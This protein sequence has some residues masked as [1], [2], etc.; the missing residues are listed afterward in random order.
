MLTQHRS[1]LNYHYLTT[2]GDMP[3][4]KQVRERE[5]VQILYDTFSSSKDYTKAILHTYINEYGQE[6]FG[7]EVLFL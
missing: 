4:M 7:Q 2:T 6:K 5:R 1:G 3:W